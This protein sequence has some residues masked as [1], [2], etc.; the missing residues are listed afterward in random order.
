MATSNVSIWNQALVALGSQATIE[1]ES[2]ASAPADVCRSVY[3]DAVDKMLSHYDWEW[4]EHISAPLN[5]LVAPNPLSGSYAYWFSLPGDALYVREISRDGSTHN[6]PAE[7]FHQFH[8]PGEGDVM[9]CDLS[10]PYV[11]FTYKVRDPQLFSAGSTESLVYLV[12]S[13]IAMKITSHPEMVN[14]MG[15]AYQR[16]LSE[17]RTEI[18]SI[19]ERVHDASWVSDRE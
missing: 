5:P 11:R 17:A 9:A 15:V 18:A 1:S 10:S 14:S 2:E 3:L 4:A 19:E 6:R 12:A 7:R 16:S 8:D 13:K